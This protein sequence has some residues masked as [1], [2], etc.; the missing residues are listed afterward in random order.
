M[1]LER[2]DIERRLRRDRGVAHDEP[3]VGGDPQP[4]RDVGIVVEVGD[5]D[6]VARLER[7]RDSVREQEVERR[8][9]GAERDL[10]RR[11]AG[12]VGRRAPRRGDQR[13]RLARG[14]ERA[15]VVGRATSQ[16]AGDRLDHRVGDLRAA[17]AVE[18]DRRPGQR[19]KA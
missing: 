2:L 13:D 16:M 15:A 19:G 3:M 8:H 1:R 5:H 11:A 9:V 10:L 7:A 4:R 6:L 12:Q 17:G 14:C 18:E